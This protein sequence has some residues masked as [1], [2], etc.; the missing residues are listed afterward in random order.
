MYTHLIIKYA[1]YK[2]IVYNYIKYIKSYITDIHSIKGHVNNNTINLHIRYIIIYLLLS[3]KNIIEKLVNYFDK[4][5]ELIEIKKI[6]NNNNA[7]ILLEDTTL[8]NAIQS[9]IEHHNVSKINYS[10]KVYIK[11][12]ISFPSKICLKKFLLEY[13]NYTLENI[14]KINNIKTTNDAIIYVQYF[15]KGI[16]KEITYA[17]LDI[18]EK[19]LGLV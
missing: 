19:Q 13:K 3:Y 5:Y 2:S 7:I 16:K 9:H 18:K 15:E 10:P 1:E 6:I 8:S 12:E 14:L 11:F 4:N 17:Y